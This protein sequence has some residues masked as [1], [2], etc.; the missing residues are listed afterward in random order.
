MLKPFIR[1]HQYNLIKKQAGLQQHACGSVSDP[2]VVESVRQ[3]VWLRIARAFPDAGEPET[4][5]LGNITA[6]GTAEQF[7]HYL[8]SLEP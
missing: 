3:D 5:L 6:A 1:N 4:R 7:H 2:K 8:Q